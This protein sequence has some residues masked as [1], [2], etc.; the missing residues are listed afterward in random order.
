MDKI[1]EYSKSRPKVLHMLSGG[2]DSFLAA[3]LLIEQG[4]EL[5][6]ITFDNGC[7]D[8]IERVKQVA[9]WIIE[10]YPNKNVTYL[11]VTKTAMLLHE[12]MSAEWYRKS[13]ERMEKFP[14]LQTYQAHCLS[15]RTAMYVHAIAYCK[16]KN[17]KFLSEGARKQQGFFVELPPM[18]ERYK[19]LCSTYGIELLLPVYDLDSDQ[20]RKRLLSDRGLS[21]KTLEP[22]C[23]L[24]CP[25]K[26]PLTECEQRDLGR[27][28]DL[29]LKPSL[30]ED[31]NGLIG[32][33]KNIEFP[34]N[35]YL[36]SKP[37][38]EKQPSAM[39]DGGH[40]ERLKVI[41]DAK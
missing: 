11:P 22:Q 38:S 18:I 31:I 23:Y 24:G 19:E 28:Y 9:D 35:E 37:S 26:E 34:D 8:E 27:Y 6:M 21:T 12:Y 13:E 41:Y 10:R 14:E 20:R 16:A 3:C 15:C 4:Y 5:Q 17:I 1:V 30:E 39:P 40:E 25:L 7:T 36:S 2:R 32:V 33:K 29:E